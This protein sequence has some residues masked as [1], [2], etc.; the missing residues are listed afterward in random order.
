[1]SVESEKDW[2]GLK[3]VGRVVAVEPF[4]STGADRVVTAEDG[5]TLKTFDASL[6]VQYE[7]TIVITRRQPIILTAI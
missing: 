6:C 2:E 7:H 5:W 4:L 3:R 1:M